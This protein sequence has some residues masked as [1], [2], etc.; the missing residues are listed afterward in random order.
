MSYTKGIELE[1]LNALQD[2]ADYLYERGRDIIL[3]ANSEAT[4]VRD[5]FGSIK[6]RVPT[7]CTLHAFPIIISPS[8]KQLKK[9]GLE[10]RVDVLMTLATKHLTDKC[11]TYRDIDTTRY[12]VRYNGDLYTIKDKLQKNMF[13]HAYLNIV[14]GLTRK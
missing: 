12:E 9:A 13:S 4:I 10:E 3:L 8:D 1:E 14:L 5:N 2:A 7:E 6:K 11:L